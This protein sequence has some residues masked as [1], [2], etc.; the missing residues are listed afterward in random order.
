M[1]ARGNEFAKRVLELSEEFQDVSAPSRAKFF[2][3]AAVALIDGFCFMHTGRRA[4]E[5]EFIILAR[6]A[7]KTAHEL[8]PLV[9][10]AAPGKN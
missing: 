1:S 4:I 10:A 6:D 5:D 7:Y 9:K 3:T 8:V 2:L